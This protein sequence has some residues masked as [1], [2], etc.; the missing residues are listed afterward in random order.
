[1]PLRR[2]ADPAGCSRL[3]L[4]PGLVKVKWPKWSN[5]TTLMLTKETPR[6]DIWVDAGTL[7]FGLFRT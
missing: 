2:L 5:E 1:M 7:K 3:S 6:D 4:H